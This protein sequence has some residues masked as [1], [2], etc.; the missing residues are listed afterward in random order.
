MLSLGSLVEVEILLSSLYD[1]FIGLV[2]IFLGD[3]VSVLSH[4]L[5]ALRN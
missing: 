1:Y 3:D 2:E 5:H 4:G